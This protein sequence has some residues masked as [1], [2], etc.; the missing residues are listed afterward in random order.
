MIGEAILNWKR[1]GKHKAIDEWNPLWQD[2]YP[3]LI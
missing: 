1:A 2:L 3:E